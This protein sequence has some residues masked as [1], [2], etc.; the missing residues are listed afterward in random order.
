MEVSLCIDPIV[1]VLYTIDP[2]LIKAGENP[3]V[4]Q[5]AQS[6]TLKTFMIE[7]QAQGRWL[8]P[9]LL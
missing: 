7:P 5:R 2:S 4:L 3:V 1:M 8:P 9:L 6:P